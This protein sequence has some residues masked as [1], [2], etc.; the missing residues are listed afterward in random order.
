M[1]APSYEPSIAEFD[2]VLAERS[3]A[4]FVEQTTPWK[5]EPWQHII[6]N[7]LQRLRDERGQRLL[8]HGPP[9]FGKSLLVSQR[10]PCWLIGNDPLHRVRLACYNQTHAERFS[11][12]NLELMRGPE[13]RAAFPSPDL[14]LPAICSGQRWSTAARLARRDAQE[15][16]IALGLGSGFTGVGADLLVLDDPY[17]NREEAYSDVINEGIWGWWTDV[18]I[19]RL[20]PATNVVVMF[21]RWRE[22]DLAGRLLEQGGWENMRF[23]AIGDGGEDDPT[24][25][26]RGVPLSPRYSIEYLEDVRRTQGPSF[27][28]LYQ[29]RPA[30][31]E[32]NLFKARFFQTADASPAKGQRI[33][34]WDLAATHSGGDWSVGIRMLR[35][36][37]GLFWVEDVVRG[38]WSP[39]ERDKMIRATAE[40][41][42]SDVAVWIEEEGGSAGKAQTLALVKLLAGFNARGEHPTGDKQTRAQPLAAQ[43]EVGNVRFLKG[44][45]YPC[46]KGELLSFPSGRWDDQ[47]DALSLCFAKLAAKR[48]VTFF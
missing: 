32:G 35:D 10:F 24:G 33:R 15:S 16:M 25:R 21:H 3:L 5:L 17:K 30:P 43:M 26:A 9:Q 38:Q 40:A 11:R 18:V 8:I 13:F 34:A 2:A 48:E 29:G 31:P 20:N 28:A 7:R 45:W 47:A 14:A 27:D 37:E 46:L 41:D 36:A 12:V 23:P 39:G 6:C 19:P 44:T 4:A 22:M 42:G 1:T